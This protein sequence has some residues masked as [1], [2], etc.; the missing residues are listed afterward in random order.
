MGEGM[1][2]VQYVRTYD[3]LYGVRS[4]RLEST[5]TVGPTGAK[6]APNKNEFLR[7]SESMC[8]AEA[9]GR[10]DDTLGFIIRLLGLEN[11][12]SHFFFGR[13]FP[14]FNMTES[15]LPSLLVPASKALFWPSR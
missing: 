13:V 3:V 5:G 6:H 2:S 4:T 14:W 11:D 1:N 8:A 15:I 7:A 9:S 10:T 12:R